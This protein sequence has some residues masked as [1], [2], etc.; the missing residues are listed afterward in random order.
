MIQVNYC[1][2][3][4]RDVMRMVQS[5]RWPRLGGQED[6]LEGEPFQ[7]R[8]KEELASKELGKLSSKSGEQHV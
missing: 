8:S 3:E 5:R 2:D 7:L 4:Y 6:F 1:C